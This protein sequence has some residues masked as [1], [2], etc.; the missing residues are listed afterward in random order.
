MRNVLCATLR[1]RPV[2]SAPLAPVRSVETPMTD[3]Q[4]VTVVLALLLAASVA[5]RS[6]TPV[7]PTPSA[8]VQPI[9]YSHKTHVALGLDCTTCHVNPAP[10]KLM[11]F[12]PTS[13]C[14]ECH[15]ALATDRPAIQ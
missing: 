3:P 14:M 12:P 7:V 1:I 2:I 11:T 5:L 13:L 4:R 6:Q 9:A 8:P 15:K 10:G